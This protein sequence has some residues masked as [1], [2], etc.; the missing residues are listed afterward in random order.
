VLPAYSNV[1]IGLEDGVQVS[2]TGNGYYRTADFGLIPARSLMENVEWPQGPDGPMAQPPQGVCHNYACLALLEI[3]SKNITV[4]DLRQTF[5]TLTT[6]YVQKADDT[7]TGSLVIEGSLN[8]GRS[9]TASSF[10]GPLCPGAIG[11]EQLVDHAV[12]GEKLDNPIGIVPSG[13]A[14]LGDTANALPGYTYT[15]SVIV[16]VNLQPSCQKIAEI[17]SQIARHMLNGASG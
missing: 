11:T 15:C 2:F 16:S 10:I 6:A 3:T 12:T 1:W 14:I 13:F 9:V 17:P 5:K 4:Q 8:V 7:L